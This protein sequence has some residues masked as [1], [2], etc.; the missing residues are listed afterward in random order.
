MTRFDMRWNIPDRY[1][2]ICKIDD[3]ENDDQAPGQGE[4]PE[5]ENSKVFPTATSEKGGGV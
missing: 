4:K 2:L 1:T 3:V 5:A